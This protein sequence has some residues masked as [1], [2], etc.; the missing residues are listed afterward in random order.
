MRKKDDL[1]AAV[2]RDAS[3]LRMR[4]LVST[5]C[6]T[7]RRPEG[8]SR[9]VLAGKSR[10]FFRTLLSRRAEMRIYRRPGQT[11]GDCLRLRL[12]R[13]DLSGGHLT[14][15]T[16]GVLPPPSRRRAGIH[17]AMGTG[18]RRCGKALGVIRQNCSTD[19][20]SAARP[21]CEPESPQSVPSDQWI[22]GS[23]SMSGGGYGGQRQPAIGRSALP[24]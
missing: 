11:D 17:G 6:L 7:L 9:R 5:A 15:V 18:L 21:A 24:A 16:R 4:S 1:V 14:L 3:L 10:F 12:R 2:L 22:S 19:Q 23:T 13:H 20:S 8:L